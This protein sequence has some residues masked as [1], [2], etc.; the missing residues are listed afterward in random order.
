M[1]EEN[2]ETLENKYSYEDISKMYNS[3]NNSFESS[4]GLFPLII[5]LMTFFSDKGSEL[6]GIEKQLDEIKWLLTDKK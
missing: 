6:K 4:M 5:L 1:K 2:K 3:N